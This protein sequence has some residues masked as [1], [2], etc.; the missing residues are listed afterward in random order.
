VKTTESV[1]SRNEVVNEYKIIKTLGH[2]SFGLVSL[3]QTD[4]LKRY[5]MKAIRRTK[6]RPGVPTEMEVL[7][8]LVHRN[9]IRLHEIINDPKNDEIFLIMDFL[10]GGTL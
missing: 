2:G 10:E 8:K 7:K 5:A 4:T 6:L 3:V 9:V 1:C